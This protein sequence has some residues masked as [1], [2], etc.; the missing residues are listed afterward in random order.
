MTNEAIAPRKVVQRIVRRYSCRKNQLI[1]V[2]LPKVQKVCIAWM[3]QVVTSHESMNSLNSFSW[4]PDGTASSA[5]TVRSVVAAKAMECRCPA[6]RCSAKK[7]GGGFG[8]T[9][10]CQFD[11]RRH[12]HRLKQRAALKVVS[13]IT[14]LW[15]AGCPAPSAFFELSFWSAWLRGSSFRLSVY[16]P[17][18]LRP[19]RA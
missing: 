12:N 16:L 4:S 15:M 10:A 17:L 11:L 3:T 14:F 18:P 1:G 2:Q 5:A 6:G 8:R 9:L 7:L 19:S 13:L